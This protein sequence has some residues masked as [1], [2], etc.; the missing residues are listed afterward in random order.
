VLRCHRRL[1]DLE[2]VPHLDSASDPRVSPLEDYWSSDNPLTSPHLSDR[3]RSRERM[4][5]QLKNTGV[6][7][8]Q[9]VTMHVETQVVYERGSDYP[10]TK[11]RHP[12]LRCP[13][14]TD[15]SSVA[16]PGASE[17]FKADGEMDSLHGSGAKLFWSDR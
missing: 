12:G 7:D 14:D 1:F 3:I 5:G 10:L 4:R 11:L 15:L 16:S 2:V 17:R 13:S 9:K 8:P 6:I